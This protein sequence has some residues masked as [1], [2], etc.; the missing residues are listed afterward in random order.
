MWAYNFQSHGQQ[1]VAVDETTSCEAH[2]NQKLRTP[3]VSVRI[4]PIPNISDIHDGITNSTVSCFAD[5]IL[6]GINDEEDAL[7]LQYYLH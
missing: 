5:G 6:Q 3:M 1:C 2:L 4:P 7:M